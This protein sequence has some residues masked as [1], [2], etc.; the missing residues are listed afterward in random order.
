M[1][2]LPLL[3]PLSSESCSIISSSSISQSFTTDANACYSI[4]NCIF[5]KVSLTGLNDGGAVSVT[6]SELECL[7]TIFDECSSQRFGGALYLL[8]KIVLIRCCGRFCT[9]RTGTFL[10]IQDS[11]YGPHEFSQLTV[12][13]CGHKKTWA[14]GGTRQNG[15][16][17]LGRQARPFFKHVNMTSN[18]VEVGTDLMSGRSAAI[19]GLY[20]SD[21]FNC[22]FVTLFNN[23]G[24]TVVDCGSTYLT[25]FTYANLVQNSGPF[26]I[27]Y[28]SVYGLVLTYC[29]FLKNTG[30]FDIYL[31]DDD[32][33]TTNKEVP[34]ILSHCYFDK[35]PGTAS[36]TVV[37]DVITG[38]THES[39][40]I[41]HFH[42]SGCEAAVI[43]S[44]LPFSRTAAFSGSPPVSGSSGVKRELQ[45]FPKRRSRRGRGLARQMN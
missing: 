8:C 14:D 7:D 37:M 45:R 9:A 36:Y 5:S 10:E 12:V 16:I 38:V 26:G 18:I 44:S 2:F 20:T 24:N 17:Y 23:S 42:T 27:L 25:R 34:F 40:E 22:T 33:A 29:V 3:C 30:S 13:L 35:L 41:G 15:G 39:F 43:Y 1:L 11:T 32:D 21:G 6:G 19:Y 4:R 31:S 28:G